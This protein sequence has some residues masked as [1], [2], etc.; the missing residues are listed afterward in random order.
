MTDT[1]TF[2]VII[3]A[4]A[5]MVLAVF[6]ALRF[7]GQT[8]GGTILGA[9]APSIRP[10]SRRDLWIRRSPMFIEHNLQRSPALEQRNV[11]R[12]IFSVENIALR[13]SAGAYYDR[14]L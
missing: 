4:A 5:A 8:T 2:L 10:I 1:K 14:S 9:G 11:A 3:V 12:H 6:G 7:A 13:W